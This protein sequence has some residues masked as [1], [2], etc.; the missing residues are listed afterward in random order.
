MMGQ[1]LRRNFLGLLTVH[2]F[3]NLLVHGV[4]K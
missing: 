2:S 4:A 1:L 3:Y